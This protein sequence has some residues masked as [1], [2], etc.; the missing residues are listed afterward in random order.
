MVLNN[1]ILSNNG[2]PHGTASSTSGLRYEGTNIS[3]DWSCGV[4]GIGIGDPLLLPL[5]NNG[6]PTMTHAIPHTS[7]AYNTGVGCFP[8]KDQRYVLRD[9]KCDVGA[10]EFNDFTKVTITIDPSTKLDATP[11]GRCSRARSSARATTRSASRSSCIRI[12]R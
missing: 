6:G 8:T 3:N 1:S 10:F 9:A 12:R 5:A 7:P 4:V 2:S 11:G